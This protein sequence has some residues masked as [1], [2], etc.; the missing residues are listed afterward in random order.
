M[1]G[2]PEIVHI[3]GVDGK[4]GAAAPTDAGEERAWRIDSTQTEIVLVQDC[5]AVCGVVASGDRSVGPLLSSPESI[6]AALQRHMRG[7]S[8]IL[9]ELARV[10]HG[11]FGVSTSDQHP[12]TAGLLLCGPPGSGAEAGGV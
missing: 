6:T 9:D 1:F 3:C 10:L 12:F 2:L 4:D 11:C 5:P 8:E 7:N